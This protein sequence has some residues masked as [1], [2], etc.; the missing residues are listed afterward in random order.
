MEDDSIILEVRPDIDPRIVT[1]RMNT[2][3]FN[4]G[5]IPQKPPVSAMGLREIEPSSSFAFLVDTSP[6]DGK[7]Q[8]RAMYM[9]VRQIPAVELSMAPKPRIVE[10]S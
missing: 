6:V 9:D 2:G 7:F 10:R 1:L 3:W 8:R 4:R 5:I